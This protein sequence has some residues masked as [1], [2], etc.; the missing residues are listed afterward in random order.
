MGHNNKSMQAIYFA[1]KVSE[2]ICKFYF[3][4]S[5]QDATESKPSPSRSGLCITVH[6]GYPN[7]EYENESLAQSSP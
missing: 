7:S 2:D 1:I 5:L 3:L 4:G 6:I